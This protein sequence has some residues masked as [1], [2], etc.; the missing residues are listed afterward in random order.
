MN[1]KTTAVLAIASLLTVGAT[2][3]AAP[4][5]HRYHHARWAESQVPFDARAQGPYMGY[6]QAPY[7]G[8]DQM[9]GSSDDAYLYDRAKGN[10]D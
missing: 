10:I 3:M 5:S 6:A 1:I 7:A 2:A 9:Y 8:Y 4:V